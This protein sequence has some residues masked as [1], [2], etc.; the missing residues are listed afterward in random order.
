MSTDPSPHTSPHTPL[1][2]LNNHYEVRRNILSLKP[3]AA[4]ADDGIT[5]TTLRHISLKTLIYLTRLSNRPLR[6]G[7]FPIAW[8]RA[9]VIPILKPNKPPTDPNSFRPISL[10]SIVGN[11]FE[12]I[13]ASHIS[14]QVNQNIFYQESS[15]DSAKNTPPS[16]NLPGSPAI[17]LMASNSTNTPAWS[18]LT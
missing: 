15:L 12:R 3:R 16:L 2:K 5:S 18:H 6:R 17:S 10:F 11:L 1:Q 8:E 13:I 4:P 9:K 7:H 14:T